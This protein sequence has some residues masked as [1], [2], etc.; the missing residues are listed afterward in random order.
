MVG[1][2]KHAKSQGLLLAIASVIPLATFFLWRDPNRSAL[3]SSALGFIWLGATISYY[4]HV[5][6]REAAWLFALLPLAL[7]V[8]F[9]LVL[10]LVGVFVGRGHW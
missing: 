1:R 5:R 3:L 8:F 7:G 6:T 2:A 4:R 9:V 10:F